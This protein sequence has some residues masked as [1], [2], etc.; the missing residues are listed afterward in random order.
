MSDPIGTLVADEIGAATEPVET[1]EAGGA[2]GEAAAAGL[3]AATGLAVLAQAHWPRDGAA[4]SAPEPVPG[5][6]YSSFSPLVVAAAGPCLARYYGPAPVPAPEGER[7]ALILASVRGDVAVAR[8]IAKSVDSGRRMAPLLFY[9][10]VANAVLGH[11]GSVW[12][13]GGPMLCI[14][15]VTD[16][17]PDALDTAAS[18]LEDGDADT[19]LIVLAEQA[20][21]EEEQDWSHALLVR[22]DPGRP[23]D[24]R[25]GR[26]TTS[27]AGARMENWQGDCHGLSTH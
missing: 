7:I 4:G 1:V 12:G 5:F 8:A 9:Q 23:R 11:L 20:C 3:A 27:L 26:H 10:S 19:A 13:V 6:A 17:L 18:V 16:P 15:P 24:G 21:T 22:L 2:G 14:S 25:V